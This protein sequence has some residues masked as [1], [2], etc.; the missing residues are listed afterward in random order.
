MGVNNMKRLVL[1]YTAAF[2]FFAAVANAEWWQDS[3]H[4]KYG[5]YH[6]SSTFA[7]GWQRGRAVLWAG[8]GD[9]LRS[10]GRYR[11]Y[12]QEAYSML[13]DNHK[14]AVHTWWE[15]KDEYKE[16]FR[17]DHP[18]YVTRE[19]KRLDMAEDIYDLKKRKEDLMNKGII[20]KP[21]PTQI[22]I[23]GKSYKS[24]EEFRGSPDWVQMRN[25][26]AERNKRKPVSKP[27]TKK[28]FEL[29]W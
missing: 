15:L 4:G 28:K 20:P 1:F 10:L 13:I 27:P 23:N 17:R 14:K 21:R 3:G 25:E 6:H 11:I 19:H 26:A 8:K 9:F 7:E 24:Y 16:R 5:G 18:D 12:N 22:I 2:F 29:I